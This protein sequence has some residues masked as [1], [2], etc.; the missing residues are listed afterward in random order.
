MSIKSST[1]IFLVR[2]VHFTELFEPEQHARR[3]KLVR[4]KQLSSVN[5]AKRKNCGQ[6]HQEKT[7]DESWANIYFT[8]EAHIDP[9]EVFQQYI[10]REQGTRYEPGNV[11]ELPEKKGAKFHIAA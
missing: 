3:Y 10:L 5:K 1:S 7:T 8:D 2:P 9:T 11:Q 6:E 4:V